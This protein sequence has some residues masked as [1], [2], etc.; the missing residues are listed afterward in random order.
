M[1]CHLLVRLVIS[2]IVAFGIWLMLIARALWVVGL[3][4]LLGFRS[5]ACFG[6]LVMA[7]VVIRGFFGFDSYVCWYFARE[8]LLCLSCVS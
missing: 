3:V 5:C 7:I 8:S 2:L 4:H 6:Q 1:R